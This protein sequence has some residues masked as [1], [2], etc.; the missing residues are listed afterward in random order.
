M[1]AFFLA[2]MGALILTTSTTTAAAPA[3]ASTDLAEAVITPLTL[4]A[5][6]PSDWQT[7]YDY[8]GG[9]V[10]PGTRITVV[11][12]MIDPVVKK[13]K[14]GLTFAFPEL[15]TQPQAAQS[16]MTRFCVEQPLANYPTRMTVKFTS[17]Y[18]PPADAMLHWNALWFTVSSLAYFEMFHLPAADPK[19][20]F[21]LNMTGENTVVFS[22]DGTGTNPATVSVN[23]KD[24]SSFY[25]KSMKLRQA[26]ALLVPG[27]AIGS[28]M[29]QFPADK[30]DWYT[31]NHVQIEQMR[32]ALK[33]SSSAAIDLTVKGTEPV[34]T[35]LEV[36]DS[37]N[38]S[39]G[40]ILQDAMVAPG[41]YRLY[42]SGININRDFPFRFLLTVVGGCFSTFSVR[43][44][45]FQA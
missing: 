32:P 33:V 34:R 2:S 9:E 43:S 40:F 24:V 3:T 41:K 44:I 22:F 16:L 8:S 38:D 37:S 25:A 26:G 14:D 42:W 28:G 23:D 21:T 36:V 27:I 31:I 29:T 1:A 18:Q 6:A 11:G 5:N 30:G 35:S 19:A 10:P 39:Q 4:Q 15:P 13:D 12:K 17:H 45:V 7:V 20:P